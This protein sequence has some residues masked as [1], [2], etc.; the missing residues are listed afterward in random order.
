MY[1]RPWTLDSHQASVDVPHLSNLN[2]VRSLVAVSD[3]S[4]VTRRRLSMKQTCS[5]TE[6]VVRSFSVAWA[7]Y[8]RENVVTKPAA[9]FI[10]QFMLSCTGDPGTGD[11]EP[12]ENAVAETKVE[13]GDNALSLSRVHE[14]LDRTSFADPQATVCKKRKLMC[15]LNQAPRLHLGKRT[16][17]RWHCGNRLQ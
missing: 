11:A 12:E 4:R 10:R 7:T 13:P 14:V 16:K 9:G 5:V 2:L 1:L 3:G 6:T 17:T 15:S 8:I